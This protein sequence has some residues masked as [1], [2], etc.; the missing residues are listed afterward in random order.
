MIRLLIV[1]D[2][3]IVAR[4]IG[5]LLALDYQVTLAFSGAEALEKLQ[6]GERFDVIIS[7]VSMP[8][9]DGMAFF[10]RVRA[11]CPDQADCFIFLTG[12]HISQALQT[13]LDEHRRPHGIP[14]L[15]KPFSPTQLKALIT[16]SVRANQSKG[17]LPASLL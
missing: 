4:A 16:G 14:V 11:L 12:G 2:E 5:R 15:G 13:F 7:D 8:D 6:G 10:Q 17:T 9:L 1:D 3:R